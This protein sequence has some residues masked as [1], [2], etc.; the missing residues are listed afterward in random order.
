MSINTNLKGRLRNTQ[1]PPAHGLRIGALRERQA[2]A[3]QFV[4]GRSLEHGAGGL[5]RVVAMV[6]ARQHERLG[7]IKRLQAD[8]VRIDPPAAFFQQQLVAKEI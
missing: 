5:L 6:F 2:C 1:L 4:F 3:H 8:H 7:K